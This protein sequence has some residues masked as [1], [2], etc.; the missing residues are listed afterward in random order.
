MNLSTL[1]DEYLLD[2][3]QL[4][5]LALQRVCACQYYDLADCLDATPSWELINI[6]KHNYDCSMCGV[7]GGK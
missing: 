6:I 1:D 5:Q 2:R 7:K 4:E 3:E